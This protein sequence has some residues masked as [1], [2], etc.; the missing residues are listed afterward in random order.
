MLQ[1]LDAETIMALL[2]YRVVQVYIGAAGFMLGGASH[3]YYMLT[4]GSL[5]L[6][7]TILFHF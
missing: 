7:Y 3:N 1:D 5:A 6:F 2:D 4:A